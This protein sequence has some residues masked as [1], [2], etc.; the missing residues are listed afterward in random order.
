MTLEQSYSLLSPVEQAAELEHL[1]AS[2]WDLMDRLAALT[3]SKG[4]LMN[5]MMGHLTVGS[6]L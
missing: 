6:E 5:A 2:M 3:A 1:N 4:A